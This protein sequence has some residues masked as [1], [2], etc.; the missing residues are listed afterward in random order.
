MTALEKLMDNLAS[1]GRNI[2]DAAG[3]ADIEID[4]LRDEI[5]DLRREIV[6]LNR[7]ARRQGARA[8]RRGL[9]RAEDVAEDAVDTVRDHPGTS[10]VALLVAGYLTAR[11]FRNR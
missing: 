8:V 7:E 3:D 11:L 10:L 6:S 4:A 5:R 9:D 1:G 2:R